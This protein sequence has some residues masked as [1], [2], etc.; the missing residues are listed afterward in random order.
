MC[1]IIRIRLALRQTKL[2]P[3]Y[4]D[5]SSRRIPRS[6]ILTWT[7]HWFGCT[8]GRLQFR[9]GRPVAVVPSEE[10]RRVVARSLAGPRTRPAAHGTLGPVR[11]LGPL[12]VHYCTERESCVTNLF[13]N[14]VKSWY[15]MRY[16][17]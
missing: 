12:T 14:K 5:C 17:L 11:P 2:M 7:V 16:L 13:L 15:K 10:G 9:G 1:V 4:R 8:R 6:F 3:D